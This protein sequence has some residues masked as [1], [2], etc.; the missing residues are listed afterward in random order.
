MEHR[1]DS[2]LITY[3]LV[4]RPTVAE[5]PAELVPRSACHTTAAHEH[6]ESQRTDSEP[7]QH[8]LTFG[9][10]FLPGKDQPSCAPHDFLFLILF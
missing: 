6:L 10:P 2:R 4:A 8:L 7:L 5:S 9:P 3:L 1:G